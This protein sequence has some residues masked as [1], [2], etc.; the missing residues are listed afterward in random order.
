MESSLNEYNF[1][2]KK[3]ISFGDLEAVFS[4]E[5]NAFAKNLRIWKHLEHVSMM[6]SNLK[7]IV[8]GC[9]RQTLKKTF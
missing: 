1:R 8:L 2:F 4:D 6:E 7:N 9:V 3:S 5:E